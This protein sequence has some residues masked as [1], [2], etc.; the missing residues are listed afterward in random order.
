MGPFSENLCGEADTYVRFDLSSFP[1]NRVGQELKFFP[2][3]L[4]TSPYPIL[5]PIWSLPNF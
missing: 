4:F 5:N 2:E 3:L 1:D